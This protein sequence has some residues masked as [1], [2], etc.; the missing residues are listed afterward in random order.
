MVANVS[1]GEKEAAWGAKYFTFLFMLGN[2]LDDISNFCSTE[3]LFAL[4][5]ELNVVLM[6]SFP[7]DEE[8]LL[9]KI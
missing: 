5:L 3:K 4:F 8:F 7:N 9:I 1:C 6:W 2:H